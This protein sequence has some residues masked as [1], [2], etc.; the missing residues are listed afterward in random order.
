[1]CVSAHDVVIIVV[2][3]VVVVVVVV[4]IVV[5]VVIVVVVVVVVVIVVVVVGSQA[6]KFGRPVFTRRGGQVS[7]SSCQLVHSPSSLS[8]SASW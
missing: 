5:L 2:V 3:I 4:F 6:L 7:I 8:P 1:M